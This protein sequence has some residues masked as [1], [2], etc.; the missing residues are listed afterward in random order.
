MTQELKSWRLTLYFHTRKSWQLF[1]AALLN[2]QL[3][4]YYWY[5]TSIN[6]VS[7]LCGVQFSSD[8]RSFAVFTI[9]GNRKRT[10]T[11]LYSLR[12]FLYKELAFLW[13][14]HRKYN[15]FGQRSATFPSLGHSIRFSHCWK[16][17][18]R[19]GPISHDACS[20]ERTNTSRSIGAFF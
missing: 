6:D 4:Y 19:W 3:L 2:S 17:R 16:P 20:H 10:W 18:R 14:I 9:Y 8:S 5:L 7:H 15:K 11:I 13:K 12:W 1:I